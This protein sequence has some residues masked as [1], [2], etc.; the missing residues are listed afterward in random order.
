MVAGWFWLL[1]NHADPVWLYYYIFRHN[2][3]P[4]KADLLHLEFALR[5]LQVKACLPKLCE[6][7]LDMLSVLYK[8]V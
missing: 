6:D 4:D 5:E 8:Q 2:N 7:E 3:E 1:C